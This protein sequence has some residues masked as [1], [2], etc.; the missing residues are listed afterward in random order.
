MI[1]IVVVTQNDKLPL[2]LEFIK[3]EFNL[4]VEKEGRWEI[5]A[6]RALDKTNHD[7]LFL[8]DDIELNKETF[9]LLNVFKGKIDLIGFTL[10]NIFNNEK[11]LQTTGFKLDIVDNAPIISE[12]NDPKTPKLLAHVTTSLIYISKKTIDCG[13]RFPTWPG[14]HKQDVAF[15]I[16]AWLHGLKVAHIPGD[17]IH[18]QEIYGIGPTVWNKENRKEL[19]Q[20][21]RQCLADWMQEKNVVEK[22]QKGIIPLGIMPLIHM[23]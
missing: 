3:D 2:G 4:I 22:A 16:D 10:Y 23:P 19:M 7:V 21:N 15:S 9:R 1:D 18:R 12:T 17:A 11:K 8:D 20:L 6:N 13:I 5:A 14:L